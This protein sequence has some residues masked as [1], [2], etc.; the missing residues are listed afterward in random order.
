M[1][2]HLG[3]IFTRRNSIIS[4]KHTVLSQRFQLIENPDAFHATKI[5]PLLFKNKPK[6]TRNN[7][8]KSKWK[9]ASN[10]LCT[11]LSKEK[12]KS[13]ILRTK[14]LP[15]QFSAHPYK[16]INLWVK[17]IGSIADVK[18]L[19]IIQFC[20]F[21]NRNYIYQF[22]INPISPWTLKEIGLS[23]SYIAGFFWCQM[24]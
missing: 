5:L 23:I 9:L 11:K 15:D 19:T 7:S 16:F 6:V 1:H 22:T 4:N 18:Y 20:Y 12:I 17:G 10:Y 13:K 14:P 24:S 2:S 21:W 3:K 8:D